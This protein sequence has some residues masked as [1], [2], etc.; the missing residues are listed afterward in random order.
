MTVSLV[1]YPEVSL[2]RF[3]DVEVSQ[4]KAIDTVIS[5]NA[6]ENFS[7]DYVWGSDSMEQSIPAFSQSNAENCNLSFTYSAFWLDQG[8]QKALPSEI[9]FDV[10]TRTIQ[11]NKCNPS[12]RQ[13][14]KGW[15][16][17][18]GDQYA[19]SYD[20]RIVGQVN[21]QQRTQKSVD[22]NVNIRPGCSD[23]SLSFANEIQ[24]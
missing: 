20:I 3:F 6:G 14:A 15:T 24:D 16:E 21:D 4:C 7:L 9:S 22:V 13:P 17:C 1:D 5:T 23:F 2:T 19:K 18:S 11:V 8:T 10:S 12:K